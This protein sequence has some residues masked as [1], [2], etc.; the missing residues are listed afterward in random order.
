MIVLAPGR[1]STT[2][3]W[4]SSSP[5]F[6]PIRRP[7]KS[8]GSP[9]AKG[10]IKGQCVDGARGPN[11]APSVRIGPARSDT[12]IT[13]PNTLDIGPPRDPST[14]HQ[15]AEPG[16]RRQWSKAAAQPLHA[17]PQDRLVAVDDR[18]VECL[19]DR[20]DRLDLGR[21]GAAQG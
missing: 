16:H 2:I 6:C 12:P 11:T 1:L 9:G 17:S 15:P 18:L 4:P 5:S 8:A 3:W 13:R 19:L 7:R 20:V 14:R 21:V 10:R